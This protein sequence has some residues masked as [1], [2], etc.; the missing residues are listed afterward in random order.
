MLLIFGL[1][2][3]FSFFLENL[4]FL[5]RP[6]EVGGG[7]AAQGLVLAGSQR[8]PRFCLWAEGQALEWAGDGTGGQRVLRLLWLG[9]NGNKQTILGWIAPS[10]FGFKFCVG[11]AC[12]QAESA[13]TGAMCLAPVLWEMWGA[14]AAWVL[15]LHKKIGLDSPKPF[16]VLG[17]MAP[18]ICK[19]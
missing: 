14:R 13:A 4:E 16:T 19:F 11:P 17:W 3:L 6:C 1:D 2:S 12:S 7:P 10:H 5:V 9:F 18:A 15:G 8:C